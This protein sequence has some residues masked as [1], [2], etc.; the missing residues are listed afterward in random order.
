MRMICLMNFNWYFKPYESNDHLLTSFHAYQN[1]HIPHNAVDIP[2]HYFNEA[3]THG[4]FSYFKAFKVKKTWRDKMIFITFEGVAHDAT[5]YINQKEVM[6]HQGGYVPFTADITS[7]IN[8]ENDSQI[9]MV[10]VDTHENSKIPPFGGVVDYLGYG[11]IYR[12]VELMVCDH[13]HIKDVFVMP[14]TKKSSS[15]VVTLSALK[16]SIQGAIYDQENQ[17]VSS[18]EV[19][20]TEEKTTIDFQ[21]TH[22]KL[23]SIDDPYLYRL[24]LELWIDNHMIDTTTQTFGFREAVFKPDGFYLNNQKIKLIG[25]NRHQ[26]YP[27]VGYAMPKSAQIEDV[28]YLKYTLGLNIVRTAHYPQSKHF[29]K[30][31]DEI[32][33]MVFEEIPGWQHIGDEDWQS[34]SINNLKAMILRDCNHPA[35]ILWGVRINESPDHDLFYQKTNDIARA[36]DPTRQTGGVRNMANSHFFEDVYTYNDFSHQGNN[37]G[38]E[39]KKHIT[40]NVPYLVTEYNGHMFPCKRYDDEAH[41]IEHAKRHLNVLNQMFDPNNQ[42]SGAIGWVMSDYNTHAA[43]GSGDRVCYHGVSDMFRLPKLAAASYQS[44]QSKYPFMKVLSDMHIGEYSQGQLSQTMVLT[45]M[46]Y[47]KLYQNDQY[48]KTFYPDRKTYKYLPYPPII[49][50]DFIGDRLINEE[51]FS[52]K[53]QMIAKKLFKSVM[54]HGPHLPLIDQLKFLYIMK[55]NK[56]SYDQAV[57]LFFKYANGWGTNHP[58]YRF[59]GY[60]NDAH[61][62][63]ETKGIDETFEIIVEVSK[64][65]MAIEETYDV[66]RIVV[67]KVNQ[68]QQIMPYA[69][70]PLKIKVEGVIDLIGPEDQHLTG[71]VM[72]FWVKTT[73]Q[74][75]KGIISIEINKQTII[76]EVE[77]I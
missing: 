8:W 41:R 73:D 64:T 56:L 21:V 68:F 23:W 35:I 27:Y 37:P 38:L 52:A 3:D 19:D 31:C 10:K 75:G 34:Q 65:P 51:H 33:L 36:L 7:V 9:V 6:H 43:F 48:I 5:L 50:D 1:I 58:V 77:V 71:G 61:M 18:F 74:K 57:K 76:K 32:G 70:D 40:K 25:L 62:L 20:V 49:I 66:K 54:T 24:D 67:K 69:F 26:S 30:R 29:I 16:G 12:E 59:E 22:Q 4:V 60:Q 28:D 17:K 42:I 53:D 44:Q 14:H 13:N 47:I 55:K 2:L 11:G 72:A 39:K 15:V 46:D 63:T 45:N